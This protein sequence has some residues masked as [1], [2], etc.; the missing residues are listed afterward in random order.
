MWLMDL[1]IGRTAD[2]G[3]RVFVWAALGAEEKRDELR[4]AY[5]SL[6]QVNEPSD[7][8]VSEDGK[9]AQDRIWVCFSGPL[10]IRRF[11]L[12]VAFS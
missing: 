1:T 12:F 4:G 7:Y 3:S 11:F 9:I 10:T 2:D 8:V 6:C 5:V